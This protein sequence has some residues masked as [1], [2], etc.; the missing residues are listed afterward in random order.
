MTETTLHMKILPCLVFAFAVITAAAAPA[1]MPAE[2]TLTSGRVL[3]KVSVIRWEK[4]KVVL[5]HLGGAE[6]VPFA[7]I[8]GLSKEDLAEIRAADET[9]KTKAIE[10]TKAAAADAAK[11]VSYSGQAFI[12]TQGA[13]N[14]LLGGME[15]IL[16]PA[17][18]AGDF[19]SN[20]QIV[21]LPKP[22]HTVTTDGEGRFTFQM[23]GDAEFLLIAQNKR[24]ISANH[25]ET[26]EWHVLSSQ[27]K[28]PKNILLSNDWRVRER[29]WKFAE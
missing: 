1:E 3:K 15:I 21:L 25:W 5:K 16:L 23:P 11:P 12:V 29:T 24:R 19:T 20:S 27:I 13:G 7:L 4:D 10:A 17:A 14:Y 22:L 9:K 18:A 2:V 8:V 26:Y 6:P 28:D